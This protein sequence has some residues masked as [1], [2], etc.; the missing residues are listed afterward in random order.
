MHTTRPLRE[1][2]LP[3][4]VASYQAGQRLFRDIEVTLLDQ[5]P[6]V[7]DLE[8]PDAEFVQCCLD[9]VVFTSVNLKGAAFRECNLKLCTFERCHLNNTVWDECLVCSLAMIDSQTNDLKVSKV[10]AYGCAITSSQEFIEGAIYTGAR[11][12]GPSAV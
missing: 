2:S 12:R 3:E 11:N 9:S 7:I 5:F 8:M 6:S 1:V 10:E 4:L